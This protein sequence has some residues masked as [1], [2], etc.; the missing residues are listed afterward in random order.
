[1]LSITH[2]DELN[3]AE[4]MA[5]GDAVLTALGTALTVKANVHH[6]VVGHDRG[7]NFL[8]FLPGVERDTALA[9]AREALESANPRTPACVGI[10]WF[11][12]KVS[13]DEL[14][15]LARQ[16]HT[17]ARQQGT[18]RCHHQSRALRGQSVEGARA[19]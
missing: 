16:T 9:W 8:A 17:Q 7:A 18:C 3:R 2:L 6:G 19:G 4:G 14:L 10:A 12:G 13:F 11:D 5:A 15:E 1:M